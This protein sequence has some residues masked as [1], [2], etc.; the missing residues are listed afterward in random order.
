M[1]IDAPTGENHAARYER[2]TNMKNAVGSSLIGLL[3]AFVGLASVAQ[4]T[5]ITTFVDARSGAWLS[6]ANPNFNWGVST[7]APKVIDST[8]GLAMLDGDV[9]TIRY[10]SGT[11]N[12][13]GSGIFGDANGNTIYGNLAG[14]LSGGDVASHYI[15][16]SITPTIYFMALLGAFTNSANVIVG[17]PFF[18]GNGPISFTIPTGATKLSMG[19]NDGNAGFFDNGGGVTL[20]ISET[21][22][23]EPGTLMLI[24][25]AL[26]GLVVARRG[27]RS[28][29]LRRDFNIE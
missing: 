6:S 28:A 13:G 25:S 16:R 11:A 5:T 3:A 19:F 8:S 27:R 4:A 2:R 12:G 1:N 23:P 26:T 21:P 22:A 18:I 9:L 10:V 17:Q 24:G 15:S 14:D 7:L 29:H 20:S